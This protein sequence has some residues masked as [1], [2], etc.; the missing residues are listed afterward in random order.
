MV[1]TGPLDLANFLARNRQAGG[2]NAQLADALATNLN[3]R[4][5]FGATRSLPAPPGLFG[6]GRDPGDSPERPRPGGGSLGAL[7]SVLSGGAFAMPSLL[8]GFVANNA[9]GNSPSPSLAGAFQS[10]IRGRDDRSERG[11]FRDIGGGRRGRERRGPGGER[12]R[13]VE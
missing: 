10:T 6:A 3:P 4:M 1:D 5:P 11:D 9:L 8:A 7:A 12:G 13:Q 2:V